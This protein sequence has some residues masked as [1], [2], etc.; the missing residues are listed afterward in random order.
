MERET[1]PDPERELARLCAE[2]GLCCNGALFGRVP[3]APREVEP[4]RRRALRV[5]PTATA[6]EQPCAAHAPGSGCAIYEDRPAACRAFACRLHARHRDE[7]GPLAPRL[8]IVARVRELVAALEASGF[9]LDAL[10]GDGSSPA[11]DAARDR[12]R[13]L[14]TLLTEHL[15]RAE[16]AASLRDTPSP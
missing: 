12:H 2:C 5:L 15:A 6:F 16:D 9:D 1:P 7:G 11:L 10:E 14:V 4:A 3:L 8:A 13:E